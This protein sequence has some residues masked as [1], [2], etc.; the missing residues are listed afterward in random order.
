MKISKSQMMESWKNKRIKDKI[1]SRITNDRSPYFNKRLARLFKA[2]KTGRVSPDMVADVNHRDLMR[3]VLKGLK[4]SNP[5]KIQ[6][7]DILQ[8]NDAFG[9]AWDTF[10]VHSKI[11]GDVGLVADEQRKSDEKSRFKKIIRN[12]RDSLPNPNPSQIKFLSRTTT[13][14]RK[15]GFPGTMST[16]GPSG[17]KIKVY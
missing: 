12:V 14:Q 9:D 11:R 1:I 10:Y 4:I 7:Q 16:E 17:E 3:K 15:L 8:N 6:P 13:R 2:E 5:H